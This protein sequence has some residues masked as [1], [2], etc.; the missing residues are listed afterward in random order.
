MDIR[1]IEI[2][3]YVIIHLHA[4]TNKSQY[5]HRLMKG[6]MLFFLILSWLPVNIDEMNHP[7]LIDW[8]HGMSGVTFKVHKL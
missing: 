1:S 7:Y 5:I 6:N 4:C 3:L 8:Q 2:G